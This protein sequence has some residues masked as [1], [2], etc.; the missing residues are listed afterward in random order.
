MTKQEISALTPKDFDIDTERGFLP[1][2]E[3]RLPTPSV[4][5][6]AVL[7]EQGLALP[8]ILTSGKI[9]E[10][11]KPGLDR[12]PKIDLQFLKNDRQAL[13]ETMRYF[14]FLAHAYVYAPGE[15]PAKILP[16][17]IAVPFY[18]CAKLLGRPPVLSYDS[19]ALHNWFRLDPTKPIELGNIAIAQNFLGGIDEDWF[20]LVH[21][22]IEA[23]AGKIP[24]ECLF[25]IQ[26]RTE[27][28]APFAS[29]ALA[30]MAQRQEKML[31]TM[32]RMPEHCD[33]YIYYTRVRPY[34]FGWSERSPLPNGVIYEGVDEFEGKP[35]K[36]FGETGAQSSIVPVLYAYLGIEFKKDGFM[37]YLMEMRKYMPAGHR[38]FIEFLEN[39]NVGW[40]TLREY[41][42]KTGDVYKE[43]AYN[44]CVDLLVEFL[45]LHYNFAKNYIA[46]QEQKWA[47]NPTRSGTGG[48]EFLKYLREHIETV[49][50][51]II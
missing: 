17:S 14:S 16:A 46:D 42:M 11:F 15:E 3:P 12:V 20:I 29:L 30:L 5:P 10:I 40:G 8:K 34:L 51:H 41:F 47:S 38:K 24:A 4:Y 22:D 21:V 36:F 48:T 50:A 9:R 33:P 18:K 27:K 43:S 28:T 35:Q 25:E 45:E 19:Y 7:A 49:R 13:D 1:S 31:D 39:T 6:R 44:R 23:R 37:H 2:R 26:A 32:K